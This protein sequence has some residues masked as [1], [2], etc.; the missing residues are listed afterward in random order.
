MAKVTA[1]LIAL[2]AIVLLV[3]LG[4]LVVS[5]KNVLDEFRLPVIAV[6]AIAAMFAVIAFL[7]AIFHSVD[8]ATKEHA[9]A[10]PEGSVRALIA[11]SLIVMF[12]VLTLFVLARLSS[13]D[14]ICQELASILTSAGQKR[15]AGGEELNPT[16]TPNPAAT[17]TIAPADGG[18]GSSANSTSGEA[19]APNPNVKQALDVLAA[20]QQAAQDLAKQLLTMLGT[21]LAAVSSFYFGS[22]SATSAVKMGGQVGGA[23]GAGAPGAGAPGGVGA[24]AGGAGAGGQGGGQGAAQQAIVGAG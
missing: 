18:G 21:L 15:Q 8:M 2:G 20:R 16:P 19:E 11:L 24:G 5:G 4:W 22:S 3:A 13:P 14:R 17:P 1:S 6:F 23:P 7:V 10:L 12:A 9:L